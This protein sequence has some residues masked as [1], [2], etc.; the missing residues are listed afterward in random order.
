MSAVLCS[1]IFFLVCSCN[2]E[3]K[4]TALLNNI[5]SNFGFKNFVYMGCCF[6]VKVKKKIEF[7][8]LNCGAETFCLQLVNIS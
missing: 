8:F 4:K 6:E 3:T 1:E 5:N 2:R 7:R